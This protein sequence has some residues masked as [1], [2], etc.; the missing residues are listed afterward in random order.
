MISHDS[1]ILT[2]QSFSHFPPDLGL[3]SPLSNRH[4]SRVH[5]KPSH[6]DRLVLPIVF[7]LLQFSKIHPMNAVY[8][9]GINRLLNQIR[10]VC[11]LANDPRSAIIWL[12]VEGVASNMG[13]VLTANT[14]Y[15]INIDAFLAKLT[16]QFWFKARSLSRLAELAT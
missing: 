13:T 4:K 12:N 5:R 1:Q 2:T 9:T 16:S 15:F 8:R 10:R 14:G 3:L 7:Q 6:R 11:I